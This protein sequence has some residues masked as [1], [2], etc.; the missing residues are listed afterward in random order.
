MQILSIG[1]SF[2][3]DA[4]NMLHIIAKQNGRDFQTVNL[5]I[6]GCSLESHHS[7]LKNN[8]NDYFFAA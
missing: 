8:S 4:H 1:N 5:F 7:N 6:C 3:Q 2:S